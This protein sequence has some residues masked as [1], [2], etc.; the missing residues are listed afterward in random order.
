[1]SGSPRHAAAADTWRSEAGIYVLTFE[2]SIQPIEI[3]RIHTW[4][5]LVQTQDGT[6]V[7]GA[8]LE[9][10]GGMPAH[11]HGLPTAPRQTEEL[12]G[13]RYLVEGMRFHMAGTFT[14]F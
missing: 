8:V 11:D 1:M 7:T 6:P 5:V 14:R 10:T 12:G 4:T 9:V 3:N 13:G 2:S